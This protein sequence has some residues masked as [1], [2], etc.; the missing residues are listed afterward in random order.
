VTL[1]QIRKEIAE[2]FARAGFVVP[3][4]A[5]GAIP[6]PPPATSGPGTELKN[7]LSLVRIAVAP[8]CSCNAYAAQMDVWGP[9]GCLERLPEIVAHLEAQARGRGLPFSR[10]VAEKLVRIAI[11]RARKKAS[12]PPENGHKP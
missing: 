4:T 1:D 7:L 6:A 5:S 10:I 8:N 11:G 2:R 3:A 12:N 9:D